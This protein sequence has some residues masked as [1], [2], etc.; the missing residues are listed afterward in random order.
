MYDTLKTKT[1]PEQIEYLTER[2]VQIAS[3]NGTE[4][5][6]RK[7]DQIKQW[8]ASFPYFKNHPEQLWEQAIPDDRLGRK[9]IFAW[10]KGEEA[11]D[12]TLIYHGHLDTVGVKDFGA[13]EE[14]AF[15]PDQLHD[16]FKAFEAD[17]E[18]KEEAESG[19][20]MF[21]RGAL[22]MQSGDAVHLANL[23]YF[24]E[25]VD[26]LH[27]NV[28]VMFNPDEE[29]EHK[30]I[31]SA[32]SELKR[33]Q[34]EEG[35]SFLGAVNADFISPLY[36]GD[37]TRYLY[38][39]AAGKL[40]PS[41][42][43]YGRES[44][45]GE[46][47]K[48]IDSTLVASEINRRINN[49]MNLTE[50]IEGEVV[51][52][53][54]CLYQRDGKEA[55]NVQI[56]FKSFMYFNYFLYEENPKSVIGKLKGIAREACDEVEDRLSNSYA[57]YIEDTDFPSSNLSWD[58][59]VI[60]LE[61]YLA[62]LQERGIQT[63]AVMD[64]VIQEN[65]DLELRDLS[66]KI[67]DALQ[68]Q[69]HEKKPRVILFYGPPHCPHNYLNA[70]NPRDRRIIE[71]MEK[72]A[73]DT[74]TEDV[75]VKRFFPFLSDSSYLSLHETDDELDAMI[76][77][78]SVWNERYSIPVRDIRSLSI[79]AI[80]MGV[81]GKDAHQWTERVYK[82]YSFFTLPRLIRSFTESLLSERVKVL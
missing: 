51:L 15:Q 33:L 14:K 34:E 28:L 53:P 37:T 13:I 65:K 27:G 21:G 78:F 70:E 41:F 6:A 20:W 59:D 72:V 50:K 4:G 17:T 74:K 49:N 55:Y 75:V 82:P 40:L 47:L 69:D 5:E 10:V 63:E 46:T 29:S 35:L 48:G 45:V 3:V 11:S 71:A 81:Y 1:L 52:P 61:E 22:D 30:G 73:A 36:E 31:I 7:A 2:L 32:I 56:P 8:I 54:S 68:Q 43:I 77:N 64:Q 79:P 25:H 67:V 23:L 26:R 38:T 42:Y 44:H 18:L 60:T 57:D 24:S 76:G 66:F 62:L 80:N 39:G 9:N 16:Y 58:I 12:E 19:D